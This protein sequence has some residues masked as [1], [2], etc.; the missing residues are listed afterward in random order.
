MKSNYFN[1]MYTFLLVSHNNFKLESPTQFP[2]LK[3]YLRWA[4]HFYVVNFHDL[5]QLTNDAILKAY[6]NRKNYF[7]KLHG[8]FA[9]LKP[10][11]T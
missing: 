8:Y 6:K 3:T 2:K 7:E 5:G 11:I 10:W 9:L 4:T 1:K